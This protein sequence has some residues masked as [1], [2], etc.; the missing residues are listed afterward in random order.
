MVFFGNSSG[1]DSDDSFMEIFAV[2]DEQIFFEIQHFLCDFDVLL[3]GFSSFVIDGV[4]FLEEGSLLFS[5]MEED[6]QAVIW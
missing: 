1:Y 6:I 5:F 3:L 2:C 4:D